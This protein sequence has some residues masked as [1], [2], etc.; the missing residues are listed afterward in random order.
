MNKK[1][2]KVYERPICKVIDIHTQILN[3]NQSAPERINIYEEKYQSDETP[4]PSQD[5]QL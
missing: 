3:T 4:S 2:T 1:G 5:W